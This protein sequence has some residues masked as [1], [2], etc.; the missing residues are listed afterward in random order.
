MMRCHQYHRS[1]SSQTTF[2]RS[3]ALEIPSQISTTATNPIRLALTR[4]LG[5]LS[6]LRIRLHSEEC[7][8]CLIHHRDLRSCRPNHCDLAPSPESDCLLMPHSFRL[9]CYLPRTPS[10]HVTQ[11]RLLGPRPSQLCLYLCLLFRL[12]LSPHLDYLTPLPAKEAAHILPYDPIRITT[13]PLCPLPSPLL[14]SYYAT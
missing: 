13:L 3:C 1:T 7:P 10:M 4:R 12:S 5:Q 8:Y 11:Q 9:I 14:P 2:P 6:R